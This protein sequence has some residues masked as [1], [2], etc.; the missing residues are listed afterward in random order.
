MKSFESIS[1]IVDKQ[2]KAWQ[3]YAIMSFVVLSGLLFMFGLILGLKAMKND[4]AN[5]PDYGV[6][7]I[8]GFGGF[9]VLFSLVQIIVIYKL[10]AMIQRNQNEIIKLINKS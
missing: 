4:F 5:F 2:V 9:S 10:L 8:V 7:I 6:L 3:I 1:L